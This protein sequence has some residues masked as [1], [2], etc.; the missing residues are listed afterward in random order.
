MT[1]TCSETVSGWLWYCD[2]HDS[3]GIA[4]N[5]AE[6]VAVSDAHLLF[7]ADSDHGD[8]CD[9]LIWKRVS[10]TETA[11]TTSDR[12]ERGHSLR[13]RRLQAGIASARA[14]AE[15]SNVSRQAVNSAEKGTASTRTF[16]RLEAWLDQ[17]EHPETTRDHSDSVTLTGT[18]PDGVTLTVQGAASNLPAL[19]CALARLMQP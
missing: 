17:R 3:H 18:R 16:E 5:E 15:L 11:S 2:N 4:D 9:L 10:V 7:F 8:T 14:F 12:E 6:A 13:R 1:G 19:Q